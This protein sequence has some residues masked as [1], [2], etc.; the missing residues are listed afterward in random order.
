MGAFNQWSK[1]LP[2]CPR[3]PACG[4]CGPPDPDRLRLL[5][6]PARAGDAGCGFQPELRRTSGVSPGQIKK[7]CHHEDHEGTQKNTKKNLGT[8]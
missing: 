5:L 1:E 4:G 6:T 8:I 2:G 7:D 3:E